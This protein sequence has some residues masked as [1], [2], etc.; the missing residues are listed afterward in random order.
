MSV[1]KAM[2]MLTPGTYEVRDVV[3]LNYVKGDTL[4]HNDDLYISFSS[5]PFVEI[6]S[7]MTNQSLDLKQNNNISANNGDRLCSQTWSNLR[8][9]VMSVSLGYLLSHLHRRND[10]R[11]HRVTCL[12]LMTSSYVPKIQRNANVIE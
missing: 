11:L 9:C 8:T 5:C 12:G 7:H 3:Y 10:V 6:C 1:F 2:V 4:F